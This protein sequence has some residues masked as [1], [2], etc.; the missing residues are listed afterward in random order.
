MQIYW[1]KKKRLHQKHSHRTGLVHKHGRRFIVLGHKYARH[2]VMW[3]HTIEAEKLFNIY[4]VHQNS[5]LI[6][7][8]FF[9][10]IRSDL[11]SF[12]VVAEFIQEKN[13]LFESCSL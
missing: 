8:F 7:L 10:N 1:N 12:F 3:K 2:D 13:L 5:L 6:F 9:S 4:D 11:L